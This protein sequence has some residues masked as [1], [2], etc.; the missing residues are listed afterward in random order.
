MS[1]EDIRHFLVIYDVN[2]GEAE[3]EEF[4]DYDAAV[5]SYDAVERR[6]RGRRDLDIV[7]LGA[8]SLETV[9]KTHSSYFE[10]T[11]HGFERFFQD[12]LAAARR[13]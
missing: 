6:T 3:V 1:A 2:V 9:R 7:L 10:T 12:A 5:A 8:D 13:Q 4:E 11:Q